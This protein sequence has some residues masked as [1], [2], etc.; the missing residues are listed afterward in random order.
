MAMRRIR[1][2]RGESYQHAD[3]VFLGVRREQ[4]AGDAS[5]Y[6]LPLR[7]RRAMWRRCHRLVA[8]L[9]GDSLRQAFPEKA[10]L[11]HLEGLR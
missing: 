6:F 2:P 1:S 4:F 7:F 5:R 9:R 8:I 11:G 3:A 10:P